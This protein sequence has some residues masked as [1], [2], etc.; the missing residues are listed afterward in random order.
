MLK[1]SIYI[2]LVIVLIGIG[3][4]MLSREILDIEFFTAIQDDHSTC[5]FY[6]LSYKFLHSR[7]DID[8]YFY[9]GNMNGKLKAICFDFSN[10][11]YIVSFGRRISKAYYDP[12][13]VDPTPKYARKWNT[14]FITVFYENM[15]ANDYIYLYKTRKNPKLRG[16][17]GPG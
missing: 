3:S 5:D 10:Y 7:H 2:I 12:L 11:T 17:E 6:P 9:Y 8:A 15:P 13:A 16:Y 1:N 4:H 14:R